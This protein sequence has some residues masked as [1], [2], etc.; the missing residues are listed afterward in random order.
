MEKAALPSARVLHH[1]K[2][3]RNVDPR[4]MLL[5]TLT[6]DWNIFFAAFHNVP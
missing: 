3:P 2:V 1:G 5:F 4:R 6:S